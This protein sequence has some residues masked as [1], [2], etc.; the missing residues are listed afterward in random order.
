M[1]AVSDGSRC[2]SSRSVTATADCLSLTNSYQ[3]SRSCDDEVDDEEV[4]ASASFEPQRLY[5]EIVADCASASNCAS[6]RV[7]PR[8]SSPC[9]WARIPYCLT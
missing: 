5:S 7:L 8:P 6:A 9:P 4:A 2:S 3:T 1:L